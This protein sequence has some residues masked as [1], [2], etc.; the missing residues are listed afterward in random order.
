MRKPNWR[1]EKALLRRGYRYI[2]G[3]DE[4]GRGPIAGPVFACAVVFSEPFPSI[5]VFDSK[6][7]RDGVRRKKYKEIIE[8]AVCWGIGVASN[9][10]IDRLNVRKAT[11]LAMRRAITVL[12]V[13]PSAVLIDGDISL[14]LDVYERSVVKGDRTCASIASASIIAK[15]ERDNFMCKLDEVC[16]G[17]NFSKHK[18]YPTPEHCSIVKRIGLSPYHRKSFRIL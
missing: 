5:E 14:G 13:I 15:V 3:V 9:E 12:P 11:L 7:L 17:Y 2:A 10:E 1:I 4:A 8:S 16:P 18:G 6:V